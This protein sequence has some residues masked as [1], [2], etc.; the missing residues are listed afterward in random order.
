M[1]FDETDWFQS[2]LGVRKQVV[3]ANDTKSEPG[4]VNC[5]VPQGSI[6]GPLLFL[7]YI[8][9]MPI[10]VTCKLLLYADDSTLIVSGSDPKEIACKL[11]V[12]LDS[13]RQWLLDNKLSLH[14]GKTESILFGSKKKLRK[15]T[16]FDVRCNDEII[17]QVTSVKYLGLQIDND[18]AGDSIVNGIL[19]K[20]NSRLKFIYR[21]RYMLSF[22]CRKTLCSAL[23][24][25][26]F[27][28]SCS[29]WYPGIRKEL[30][31]KL[32]IMQNKITRF[33]LDLDSRAHIGNQQLEK[34]GYLSVPDRVKQLKL[35][36]VFKIRNKTSPHYMNTHFQMLNQIEGRI[37]TRATAHNFFIPRV[38]NQG[39]KT[40][41]YTSI[42]DW[43]DLP[44][45]IKCIENEKNFK[46][47]L[48][49]TLVAEARKQDHD[50]FFYF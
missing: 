17:K 41:F 27:D 3:V 28:Y 43:N 15:V 12:E 39:T 7:C 30:T 34:A 37:E 25:C 46:E 20:A 33:I 26:H 32:H 35:G 42:K 8:N 13:C 48:K 19:K 21:N 36:H 1:G 50:P 45:D 44:N 23:I 5:G 10:S 4:I 38:Y 22:S 18:L 14:L 31:K 49:Q 24:Q 2:Y 11:S 6:L 29:S 40:F 16:S 47:K 9:D